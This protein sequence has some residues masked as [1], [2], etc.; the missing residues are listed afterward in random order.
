M[1]VLWCREVVVFLN[2]WVLL[3]LALRRVGGS[4]C[5]P[6]VALEASHVAALARGLFSGTGLRSRRSG[7]LGIRASRRGVTDARRWCGAAGLTGET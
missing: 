7:S 1:L 2:R 6:A 4:G 3:A 5:V